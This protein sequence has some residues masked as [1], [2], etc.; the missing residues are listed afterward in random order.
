[1]LGIHI[2]ELYLAEVPITVIDYVLEYGIRRME[3]KAELLYAAKPLLLLKERQ[4]AKVKHLLPFGF[5]KRM[6]KVI[7][8]VVR[9]KMLKLGVEYLLCLFKAFYCEHGQLGCNVKTVAV[10]LGKHLAHERF[11]FA[12]VI[13]PGGVEIIHALLICPKQQLL[14]AR[15]V[16]F[17]RLIGGET[18]ASVAEQRYGIAR[19]FTIIHINTASFVLLVLGGISLC[20]VFCLPL[21][22]LCQG[23][24]HWA[25][26]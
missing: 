14:C 15:F 21:C 5:I 8:N 7:I 20:S 2:V 17:A 11:A 26:R 18:H 25:A 12:A 23:R 1:M 13:R 19:Q 3:R 4:K 6:K 16:Y 24:V 10:K 22:P 9:L